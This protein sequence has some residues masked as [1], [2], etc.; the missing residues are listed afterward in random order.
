MPKKK[1]SP[2]LLNRLKNWSQI[3]GLLRRGLC[4]SQGVGPRENREPSPSSDEKATQSAV[5]KSVKPP[6]GLRAQRLLQALWKGS[7]AP[8]RG[9]EEGLGK[10]ISLQR[11]ANLEEGGRQ[12]TKK[13]LQ[14][15][16]QQHILVSL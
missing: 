3:P 12:A 16:L 5:G 14:A 2:S 15:S 13:G 6:R 7:Q 8:L 11:L 10:S 4:L 1:V 9:R